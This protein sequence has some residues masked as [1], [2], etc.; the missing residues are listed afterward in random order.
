M[1]TG[2]TL[3]ELAAEVE[4]QSDTRRDFIAPSQSIQME[5]TGKELTLKDAGTFGV[6]SVAHGQLSDRLKIP[7]R[8]YDKMLD[9]APEL[10]AGNVNHWL[11][12]SDD[13]RM[14]R[15]LD[16]TARAFLSDRYRPLD[17]FELMQSV[18]P[19]LSETGV[20]T[21]SCELTERRLYMKAVTAKLT[22]E[23][24]I[25]DVVQAGILVSNSEVGC[26]SVRIEP[27]IF[28]LVCLNLAVMQDNSVRKYHVGRIS[29]NGGDVEQ[30]FRDETREADDTAFWMKVRDVIEASFKEEVFKAS[31]DRLKQANER[32]I[33]G[34]VEGAIEIVGKE[35]SLTEGEREGVLRNLIIE[36]NV[37]QYALMNA[38]TRTS[39]EVS[40]Y[41]RATDL[42][43]VGGKIVEM[44]L[45]TWER[46]AAA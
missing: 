22:A 37:S 4:R 33:T 15:T 19:V 26:G 38:V 32:Q 39:A 46:I 27:L 5:E 34:S 12:R 18:L 24:E 21:V 11:Q 45:G 30:F 35:F 16:G 10:L 7:K 3:M 1:K 20:Q 8:Y 14:V 23:V 25:G 42:E 31:V 17:N 43:R 29:G 6:N 13:K 44:P 36:G 41:D 40:E 2:K 9:T 28:R